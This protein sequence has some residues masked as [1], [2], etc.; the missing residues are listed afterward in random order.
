[1]KTAAPDDVGEKTCIIKNLAVENE[2]EK[3]MYCKK[4]YI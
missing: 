1:M 2:D 3:N 4:H